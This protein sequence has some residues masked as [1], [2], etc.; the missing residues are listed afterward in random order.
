MCEIVDIRE[1]TRKQQL[2]DDYFEEIRYYVQKLIS[3]SNAL[4]KLNSKK[5]VFGRKRKCLEL[6]LEIEHDKNIIETF[7]LLYGEC[8]IPLVR[9]I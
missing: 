4:H 7:S 9:T 6:E 5:F 3:D 2:K 8:N 1:Y